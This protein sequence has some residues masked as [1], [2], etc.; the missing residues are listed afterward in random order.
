MSQFRVV[1]QPRAEQ[2]MF[3]AAAWIA[4]RAPEMAV[5]WHTNLCDTI[6]SLTAFP[7]RCQLAP[8]NSAF[9]EEIRQFLDQV[10]GPEPENCELL[11]RILEGY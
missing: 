2:D 11:K 10:V 6:L 9:E 5:V 3:E 4:E 1:I 8:E 7:E